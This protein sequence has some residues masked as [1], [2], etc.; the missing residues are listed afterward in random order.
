MDTTGSFNAQSNAKYDLLVNAPGYDLVTGSLVTPS[1]PEFNH[2]LMQDTISQSN[3]YQVYFE[4]MESRGL[5]TGR[6]LFN[7]DGEFSLHDDW[8]GGILENSISFDNGNHEISPAS[9]DNQG[10]DLDP[11]LFL[12]RLI[13]MDDNYYEYFMTAEIGD[14]S[15]FLLSS[16]TTKGRSIGVEG[17]FGIF[18]AIGSD[19]KLVTAIP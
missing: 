18:G 1:K 4:A 17:G 10:L 6:I 13:A 15:N 12:L 9:C 16:P 14:Y 3:N 8:C 2:E 7:K 19:Y 11:E 5:I